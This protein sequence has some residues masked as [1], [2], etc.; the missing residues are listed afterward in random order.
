MAPSGLRRRPGNAIDRWDGVAWRRVHDP[1]RG[2]CVV[3]VTQTGPPENPNLRILASGRALTADAKS[4]IRNL[5]TRMLGLDRDL[6]G[7]YHLTRPNRTMASLAERFP[8]VRL[9]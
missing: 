9:P 5:L 2:I 4:P 1:A 8:G 6:S 3:R 7:F